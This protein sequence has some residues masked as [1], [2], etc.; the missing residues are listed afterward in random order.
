[1]VNLTFDE[2]EFFRAIGEDRGEDVQ[3]FLDQGLNLEGV[4]EDPKTPLFFATETDS[5]N[6][7]SVLI[8]AGAKLD[9]RLTRYSKASGR[10]MYKDA[11]P[12]MVVDSLR[13]AKML[14]E[15]GANIALI[16][17][18][19]KNAIDHARDNNYPEI[20]AYLEQELARTKDK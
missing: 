15:A 3:S 17:G 12:L 18:L 16:D 9:A 6:S 8:K 2:Q 11:T 10:L 14:V 7:L 19:G 20:V 13:A 1:M 5:L 4:E